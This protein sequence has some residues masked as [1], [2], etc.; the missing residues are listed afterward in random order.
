MRKSSRK[1]KTVLCLG[2]FLAAVL[3]AV[4]GCASRA[5]AAV[6]TESVRN[7]EDDRKGTV[8]D[9]QVGSAASSA[10][11]AD[12][13]TDSSS[14]VI[15]SPHD[16]DPLNADI[17]AFMNRYPAIRV[18]LVAGGTVELCDKIREQI[19]TPEADV[20]WGGGADTLSAY[21]DC[22]MKYTSANSSSIDP[23][24]IDSDGRWTGESPLPMVIIYNKKVLASL[25]VKEI[26]S[27]QDLLAPELKGQIAYCQ[28]SKSGSA[29]TQLCTMLLANGGKEKGWDYVEKLFSNLNGKILDSSGKCHK[30]VA[31]GEFAAG[32]TIEKSAALY[33]DNPD[34]G[35]CYPS[36]GTSAVPDA[37]A[38]VKN[39]RHKENAEL[40]MD[41]ILSREAQEEQSTDWNRRPSRD[42]VSLPKG[43]L[44]IGSIKLVDYDFAWA[45]DE[46]EEI[47]SRFSSLQ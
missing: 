15:Y 10:D 24:F 9:A 28:P 34:I 46:K 30:L 25:G 7:N 27:W 26:T 29:Y 20:L 37:I 40:F 6:S 42:D 43:L 22:F 18:V 31:A 5:P 23:Q 14:V 12:P 16:A 19:D 17:V 11:Q 41:F 38:I 44:A 1:K 39:C 3:L 4:S 47:I 45:A 21:S 2:A 32:I 8:S 33:A 36:E 35:Y 13:D